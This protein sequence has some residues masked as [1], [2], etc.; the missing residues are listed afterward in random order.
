[1]SVLY[2]KVADQLFDSF[3]VFTDN[4]KTYGYESADDLRKIDNPF[5][6]SSVLGMDSKMFV[7]L[8]RQD[9]E[10]YA[11]RIADYYLSVVGYDDDTWIDPAGGTHSNNDDDPAYSYV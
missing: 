4:M 11:N 1:M 7:E 6:L 5:D 2:G 10:F 3:E 9:I 8:D